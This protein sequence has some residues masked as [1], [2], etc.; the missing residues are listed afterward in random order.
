MGTYRILKI[1]NRF[2]QERLLGFLP[3]DEE[4]RRHLSQGAERRLCKGHEIARQNLREA[5]STPF[6][7]VRG[8][9]PI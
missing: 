2:G 5:T 7:G 3:E 1:R 9:T 4:R 6:T 8:A